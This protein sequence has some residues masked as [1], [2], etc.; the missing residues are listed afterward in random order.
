M[1]I[2]TF[3]YFSVALMKYSQICI[4]L[5]TSRKIFS[6]F[7]FWDCTEYSSKLFTIEYYKINSRQSVNVTTTA[8]DYTFCQKQCINSESCLALY[9]TFD[10]SSSM[11][12]CNM[13]FDPT[14]KNIL[15]DN[16]VLTGSRDDQLSF[17]KCL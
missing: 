11:I 15:I 12:V 2:A 9:Q 1:L 3:Y 8:T 16:I 14:D 13:Y 5:L 6:T 10:T 17:R 4:F 7:Y